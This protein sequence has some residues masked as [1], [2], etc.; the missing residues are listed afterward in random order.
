MSF[1]LSFSEAQS[2]VGPKQVDLTGYEAP[3]VIYEEPIYEAQPV[4]TYHPT[5]YPDQYGDQYSQPPYVAPSNQVP[6]YH[7]P[8]ASKPPVSFF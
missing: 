5:S 7:Y 6:Q 8:S 1:L 4:A 2:Y 3:E